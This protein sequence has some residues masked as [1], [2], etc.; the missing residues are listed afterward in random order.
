MISEKCTWVITRDILVHV[1]II[2]IKNVLIKLLEKVLFSS[3]VKANIKKHCKQK[4][5]Q[6]QSIMDFCGN[7]KIETITKKSIIP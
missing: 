3:S 5:K 1:K 2:K 7:L 6:N 4:N